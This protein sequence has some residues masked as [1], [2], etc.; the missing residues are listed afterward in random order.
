MSSKH[1]PSP[2]IAASLADNSLSRI[3]VVRE[4]VASFCARSE[5]LLAK[6]VNR[7]IKDPE[8]S[9]QRDALIRELTDIFTG[10]NPAYRPIAGYHD[11]GLQG[12]LSADLGDYYV[13]RRHAHDDDAVAV[14]FEWL[15][16]HI[17]DGMAKGHGDDEVMAETIRIP[18]KYTTEV[19]L[20]IEKR[21]R[22][23]DELEM[24]DLD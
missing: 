1:D 3:D 13:Q 6:A 18:I 19:L 12:K 14:L 8:Y 17:G 11:A 16:A 2:S 21:Q 15:F 10:K 4:L 22:P 5:A 7:T 23:P 24:P 9:N 20:S